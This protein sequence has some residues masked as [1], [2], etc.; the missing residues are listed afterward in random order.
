MNRQQVI[1]AV[2]GILVILVL[3]YMFVFKPKQEELAEIEVQ[4]EEALA[5]E[6]ALESRIATL[7][8]VRARAPE[9]EASLATAESIIPREQAL[10]SALRQLQLAADDSGAE[11]LSVTP[12]RPVALE[13]EIPELAE[14]SVTL[15]LDGSYFQLVDFLRRVEDPAITPRGITWS[16]LTLAATEYPTLTASLSGRMFAL[17]PAPITTDVVPDGAATDP[18]ADVDAEADV[19]VTVEE[20]AA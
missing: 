6:A 15:V 4:I 2:L 8:E 18:P 11:L 10:P 14:L 5:Q 13:G 19:E 16:G 1:L 7:E 12:G 3:F 9:I 20:D 17:L